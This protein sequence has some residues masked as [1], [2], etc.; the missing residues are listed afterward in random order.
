LEFA[1]CSMGSLTIKNPG[2]HHR[3]GPGRC[4]A[5]SA[6]YRAYSRRWHQAALRHRKVRGSSK[7]M[8]A[9]MPCLAPPDI[10]ACRGWAELEILGARGFAELEANGLTNA[11]GEP[12]RLA[13][14]RQL[15]VGP[16]AYERD[17]GMIF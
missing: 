11:A 12:R 4:G 15:R 1:P 10:P 2:P 14:Y 16:H 3:A 7:K 6:E 8:R 5:G 9:E 13:D 17:L